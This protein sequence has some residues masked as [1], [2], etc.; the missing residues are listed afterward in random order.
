MFDTN[1]YNT[2]R[3]ETAPL[4]SF[5]RYTE[6]YINILEY[7]NLKSE[8]IDFYLH[9][10]KIE[11]VQG[12]ILHISVII[13]QLTE[14]LEVVIPV[15]VENQTPFKV[16]IDKEMANSILTGD[17]GIEQLGKLISIYPDDDN[18][19]DI[20]KQLIALTQSFKGPDIPTDIYLGGTIYTRYGSINPVILFDANGKRGKYIHNQAGQLIKDPYAV[21]F[22][23]PNGVFWP[24]SSITRST[25]SVHRKILNNIYKPLSLLKEDIK[26]NVY[27]GIYLKGLFH[28]APCVIKE[29]KKYM[30]SDDSGRDM[31]NRLS[32]QYELHH[33]LAGIVQ[34]PR[35]YD[36]FQENGNTYLVMEYVKGISLYDYLK[37][38]NLSTKSWT[39]V[40]IKQKEILLDF[41][42]Q[43]VS[44]LESIY[45]KG[46]VH[47][48][49]APGNFLINQNG[50]IVLID[51]ELAYSIY[52]NKP[53]PAFVMG[54]PG[55]ISPEQ[56]ANRT[57]TIKDDCYGLGALMITIFTGL[58]P[59]KFNIQDNQNFKKS[60]LFFIGD[61]SIT[62][63]IASCMS[64]DASA[65]P[66]LSS[67]KTSIERYKLN[68]LSPAANSHAPINNMNNEEVQQIIQAAINGLVQEPIVIKDNLW[69]S[70][71]S[72]IEDGTV[73][74]EYTRYGGLHDGIGG[75][76][77]LLAKA[78]KT[79]YDIT[80]CKEAYYKNW[81]FIV[82]EYLNVL[83]HIVPGLFGGA[84]GMAISLA[85]GIRSGLLEDNETNR[86]RIQLC[87]TLPNNSLNIATG[88]T[89]Q[90]LATLQCS[91]FL[92]QELIEHLVSNCV[93]IL[94][95]SQQK[96][97]FWLITDNVEDKKARN[98]I[99]FGYGTP[100][101]IW[102][103]LDYM[104][105]FDA[106]YVQK[107]VSIA[108]SRLLKTTH[109][110]KGL[111]NKSAFNRIMG[112][113]IEIG[114]ERKGIILTL[115][116]AYELTG[117]IHFKKITEEA[118]Q[119]YPRYTVKNNFSQDIGLA[120]LGELYLEAFR[121][122][123]NQE[124]QQRADW[125]AGVF[126]HTSFS[127]SD[128]SR[129]WVMDKYDKPTADLMTGNSGIIHFLLRYINPEKLG[130]RMLK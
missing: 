65:R 58:Y 31:H 91:D 54:T 96:D 35:I 37:K 101:I 66:D 92:N 8:Q 63:L 119:N 27:K 82:K 127:R 81:E 107:P 45:L 69:Y 106:P 24:Y 59:M 104:A 26:G 21:P 72:R 57:P 49:I 103:L 128:G 112:K 70:K 13:S 117:D 55:Y 67:I 62:S 98:K 77:Y 11:K 64:F 6:N 100:G 88:I 60:L 15:L 108:L 120:G 94:L 4:T 97:G 110:L 22:Q 83:P 17:L 23:L 48:D 78:Q 116:K 1:K 43:I 20:A 29:G 38:T 16:A 115:I 75:T 129:Y 111:F 114:D 3:N 74:K 12:W 61:T 121:V 30:S 125:I 2:A 84:A 68:I 105:Q 19:A 5:P 9:V 36:I 118:L 102:F 113:E 52:K 124:W 130:Y 90:C 80:A 73:Q 32:W 25:K 7:F 56:M 123:K 85:E 51:M 34:I 86:N 89:G 95:R 93:N 18:V 14:M 47:R 53:E 126:L 76:L 46:Y 39:E 79:G 87:L 28:V 109:Q 99:S 42:L 50:Q 33:D 41:I 71:L 44:L 40:T 122:F 10:G